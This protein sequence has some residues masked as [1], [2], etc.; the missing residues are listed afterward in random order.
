VDG[1]S[2][3]LQV[4]LLDDLTA[5]LYEHKGCGLLDSEVTRARVSVG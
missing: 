3:A 1:G 4:N 2:P 5:F